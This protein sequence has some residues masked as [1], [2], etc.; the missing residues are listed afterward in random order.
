MNVKLEKVDDT[1]VVMDRIMNIIGDSNEEMT[2]KF[3]KLESYATKSIKRI[4]T[5]ELT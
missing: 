1:A 4:E 2:E 3:N 5:Q